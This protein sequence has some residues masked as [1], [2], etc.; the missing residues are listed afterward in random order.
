[1]T[2]KEKAM[3]GCSWEE[4]REIGV[5]ILGKWVAFNAYMGDEPDLMKLLEDICK[6]GDEWIKQGGASV[7]AIAR[8][9]RKS[10]N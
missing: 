10:G 1:M 8:V 9:A 5:Y 4:A 7:V 3:Q 2:N 6:H